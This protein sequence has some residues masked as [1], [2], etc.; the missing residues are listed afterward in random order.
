MLIA[1]V[2]LQGPNPTAI[3]VLHYEFEGT[4]GSTSFVDLTGRHTPQSRSGA[5]CTISTLVALYGSSSL[6]LPDKNSFLA[7]DPVGTSTNDFFFPPGSN[8]SIKI[9]F[10]VA[11]S[12]EV[13]DV[14][15]LYQNNAAGGGSSFRAIIAADGKLSLSQ[16][17]VTEVSP[18]LLLNTKYDLE[19]RGARIS[20]TI[21]QVTAFLNGVQFGQSN[22]GANLGY[23]NTGGFFIGGGPLCN[24]FNGYVDRVIVTKG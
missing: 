2:M 10:Y 14:F 13:S 20:S 9:S 1:G 15:A 18:V 11:A 21:T 6:R 23:A 3:E 7:S 8:W 4:N 5:G 17:G 22:I 16:L 12:L 24:K 19:L